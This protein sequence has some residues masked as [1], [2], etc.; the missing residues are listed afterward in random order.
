MQSSTFGVRHLLEHFSFIDQVRQPPCMRFL[1]EFR[2]RPDALLHEEFLH[3]LAHLAQ[4]FPAH[5][6][7]EHEVAAFIELPLF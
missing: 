6:P 4:Q 7:W 2:S 3:A 5:Q 1:L